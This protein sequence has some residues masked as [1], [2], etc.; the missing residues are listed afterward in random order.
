MDKL[1]LAGCVIYN[2]KKELLLLHRNA[3]RVQWELPGGKIDNN[4]TP[5]ETAK[6]ELL[7]ELGIRI[8]IVKKMGEKDFTED[9]IAM[10]YVWFLAEIESGKAELIEKRFDEMRYFT[11]EELKENFSALS[12]G[13]KVFTTAYFNNELLI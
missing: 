11:W 7:E 4:E 2:D 10:N 1:K 3:K 9:G 5:E 12:E 8:N 13:A 6:R